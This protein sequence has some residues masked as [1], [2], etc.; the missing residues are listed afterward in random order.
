[1][2]HAPGLVWGLGPGLRLSI[3]AI[4]WDATEVSLIVKIDLDMGILSSGFRE[5][6]AAKVNKKRCQNFSFGPLPFSPRRLPPQCYSVWRGVLYFF[7]LTT[8]VWCSVESSASIPSWILKPGGGGG[9]RSR[10]RFVFI[11]TLW[12]Q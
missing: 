8:S 9:A 7:I 10:C 4:E 12:L 1:M 5:R 3:I 11:K 2:L 6:G